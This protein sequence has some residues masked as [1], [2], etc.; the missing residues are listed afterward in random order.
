MPFV[1]IDLSDKLYNEKRDAI[2]TA[3]HQAL[4]IGFDMPDGDKFQI[5]RL[6]AAGEIVFDPHWGGVS[7]V[8]PLS[9]QILMGKGS[10]TQAKEKMFAEIGRQLV[11]I[12][13]RS[14]D[15]FISV[16]ENGDA[17][18]DAGTPSSL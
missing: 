13:I 9:L 16:I 3:I 1:T 10:T 17:C 5:F 14:D 4:V 6:H 11:R 8:D 2:S 12:G 7:R 18:W 15:I